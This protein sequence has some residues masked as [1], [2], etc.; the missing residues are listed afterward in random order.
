MVS[1][2]STTGT[3]EFFT[4]T[5]NRNAPIKLSS[6]NLETDFVFIKPASP[7]SR[8]RIRSKTSATTPREA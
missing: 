5:K 6:T 4:G 1:V 2:S 3:L 7:Y 8:P